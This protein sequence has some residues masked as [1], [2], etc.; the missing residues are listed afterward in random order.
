MSS[1]NLKK[2]V[3]RAEAADLCREMAGD[4]E[5]SEGAEL[6]RED[7]E[8]LVSAAEILE[9]SAYGYVALELAQRHPHV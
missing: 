4:M 1:G 7:V 9:D 6:V 8:V 3:E 2:A 5:A